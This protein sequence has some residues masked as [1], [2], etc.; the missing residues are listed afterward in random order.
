MEAQLRARI[1][2]AR[3][4]LGGR[5]G[6]T[7]RMISVAQVAAVRALVGRDPGL[8]SCDP[9]AR[10]RLIDLATGVAWHEGH[11]EEVLRLLEPLEAQPGH[12]SRKPMQQFAPGIVAYFT[13]QEWV[14]TL[15]TKGS[16]VVNDFLLQRIVEL[17]GRTLSEPS[18]KFV[19]SL[20]LWLA[21]EEQ[22]FLW[23]GEQKTILRPGQE[24]F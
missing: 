9:E 20:M 24:R 3:L 19:S 7:R 18:L 12:R 21:Y 14:A 5:A 16:A 10:A 15:T 17:S 13:E 4:A 22:A 6:E 11:L 23:T 1:G 2:A 8:S